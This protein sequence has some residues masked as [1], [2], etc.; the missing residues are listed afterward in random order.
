MGEIKPLA[1]MER[2]L[3][4]DAVP[5]DTPFSVYAFPTNACNFRC[6]YCAHSLGYGAMKRRYGLDSGTMKL[7][8][9]KK[10][11]DQMAAFPGKVKVLSLTGHGEPLLNQELPE[12]VAYARDRNAASRT[13]FITNASLLTHGLSTE[14]IDAG[15]GC[16]RI[17]LQGMDAKKYEEVCGYRIDFDRLVEEIRYFYQHRKQ[18]SVYVKVMDVVLD[19]G[20]EGR[21]YEAFR[22]ISD[23]MFVERCRPVYSGV[24]ATADLTAAEDRYG[25]KHSPRAVCPLCFFM[26]GIWPN[27]DVAPCETIYRPAILGNVSTDTL[28]NMWNGEKNRQFRLMQLKKGRFQTPGCA[29]C[30]APDDVSHPED[31]LDSCAGGLLQKFN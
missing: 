27:G 23:R 28:E 16:I 10:A 9:F 19:E 30:C 18:C 17:S 14:L 11:A 6:S 12:M 4:K 13:E 8:T 3:L 15:L 21:F 22:G 5:L 2:V 7:E 1:G 24:E 26:L 20:D 25:R 31:E 29:G